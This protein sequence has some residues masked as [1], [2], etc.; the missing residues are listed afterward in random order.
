MP[1]DF[2]LFAPYSTLIQAYLEM[3]CGGFTI[4]CSSGFPHFDAQMSLETWV[5]R[6]AFQSQHAEYAF[7]HATQRLAADE[8]F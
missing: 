8:P 4:R 1:P 6:F 3:L 2:E 7:M 5:D